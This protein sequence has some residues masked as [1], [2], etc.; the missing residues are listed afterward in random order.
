[1]D[2]WVCCIVLYYKSK[3]EGAEERKGKELIFKK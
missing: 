1:M 3:K 2:F